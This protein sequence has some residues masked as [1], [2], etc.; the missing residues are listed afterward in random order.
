[1]VCS[2]FALCGLAACLC[3]AGCGSRNGLMEIHGSV[4]YDGKPV[5]DGTVNFVPVNGNGPTAAAI[6]TDGRYSV[7][8]A[9]GEK[10]VRIEAFR[11]TGH[12]RHHPNDPTS[13]MID[14]KE[15]ILP[16]RYNA[17]TE[18]AR[19]ITFGVDTCDFDLVKSAGP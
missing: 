7:R 18:L 2:K 1:M 13:R 14:I 5:Q 16:E 17:K 10:R 8:V 4:T 3:M 15:Q 9:P 19:E 12:R 6:V 11:I